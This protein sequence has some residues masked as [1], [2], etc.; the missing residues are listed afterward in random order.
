M[1]MD[2]GYLGDVT[3]AVC[4]SQQQL[5]GVIDSSDPCQMTGAQTGASPFVPTTCYPSTFAG[6]L[7]P[8]GTYCA[9]GT[10]VNPNVITASGCP[11]GQTCTFIN[12]IPNM[13][14]YG[15]AAALGVLVLGSMLGGKH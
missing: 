5:D 7:P 10:G 14:V 8:G 13:W 12:G 9:T 15:L 2:F 1:R 11:T 3:A 6:P 4:P